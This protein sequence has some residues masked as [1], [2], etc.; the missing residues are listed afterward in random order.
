MA[1]EETRSR[2]PDPAHILALAR[3]VAVLEDG[4]FKELAANPHETGGAL[5]LVAVLYLGSGLAGLAYVV[6]AGDLGT[7][8]LAQFVAREVVGG[9]VA[10]CVAWLAW[11]ALTRGVLGAVFGV[12][13]PLDRLLRVMAYS[14]VPL[15][16]T[17]VF[18]V[19][20]A[21][22]GLERV[23]GEVSFLLL[24]VAF[25]AIPLWALHGVQAAA[26]DASPRQVLL[27]VAASYVVVM[28]LLVVQGHMTGMAPPTELY[29]TG[30]RLYYG[31]Y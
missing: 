8:S 7:V 11:V 30:S 5:A 16:L 31:A 15:A 17:W 6:V 3:R 21:I 23:L 4:V 18:F 28:G 2:P 29:G 20:R 22:P 14:L 10:G 27:A 24:V 1:A 26:P 12:R 9:A 25:V 13:A 19:P